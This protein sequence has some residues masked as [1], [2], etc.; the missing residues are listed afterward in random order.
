MIAPLVLRA[1]LVRRPTHTDQPEV[2]ESP[3]ATT[4]P[5]NGWAGAVIALLTNRGHAVEGTAVI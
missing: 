1:P 4:P 5:V 2:R 3:R